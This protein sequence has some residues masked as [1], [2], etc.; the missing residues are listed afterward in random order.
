MEAQRT[1]N[2]ARMREMAKW[3]K[4][5]VM[6]LDEDVCLDVMIILKRALKK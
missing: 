4:M 2:V 6:K 1:D 5:S 3:Y